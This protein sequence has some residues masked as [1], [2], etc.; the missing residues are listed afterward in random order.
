MADRFPHRLDKLV[1]GSR[2]EAK[3]TTVGNS[4]VPNKKKK[5][6]YKSVMPKTEGQ[7][8]GVQLYKPGG[9]RPSA[10]YRLNFLSLCN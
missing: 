4:R 1:Q 9:R 6:K 5:I 8:P 7:N 3:R 2:R 10:P